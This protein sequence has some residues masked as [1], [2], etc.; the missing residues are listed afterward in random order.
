MHPFKNTGG[1]IMNENEV[2]TQNVGA[3]QFYGYPPYGYGYPPYGYGY[4]PYGY[5]YSPYGY[6]YGIGGFLFPFLLGALLF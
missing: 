2:A 5:G 3:Q 1:E 4:P 6:G